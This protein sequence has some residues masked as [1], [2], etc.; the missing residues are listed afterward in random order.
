[1]NKITIFKKNNEA[2]KVVEHYVENNIRALTN[3]SGNGLELICAI[4]LSEFAGEYGF[5]VDVIGASSLSDGYGSIK[6]LVDGVCQYVATEAKRYQ[7]ATVKPF[8]YTVAEKST[9]DKDAKQSLKDSREELDRLTDDG[10]PPE[11]KIELGE[12]YSALLEYATVPIRGLNARERK[13]FERLY[14]QE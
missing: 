8:L 11:M 10:C 5:E 2:D 6:E 13:R 12:G 14:H 4:N 7:R 9:L 1:M 3:N